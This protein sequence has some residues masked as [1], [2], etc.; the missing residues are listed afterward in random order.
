MLSVRVALE[1]TAVALVPPSVPVVIRTLT[2]TLNTA[3]GGIS[4]LRVRLRTVLLRCPER[5]RADDLYAQDVLDTL[6]RTG[7]AEHAGWCR[8]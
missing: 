1:P 3:A 6:C 5:R 8:V 2:L 4:G 7:I